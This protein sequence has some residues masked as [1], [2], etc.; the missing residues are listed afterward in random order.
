VVACSQKSDVPLTSAHEFLEPALKQLGSRGKIGVAHWCPQGGSGIDLPAT[1]DRQ[2]LSAGRA[3]RGEVLEQIVNRAYSRYTIAFVPPRF[4]KNWHAVKIRLSAE[5]IRKHAPAR[6][7]YRSGYLGSGNAP[8]YSV[9]DV[10][11]GSDYSLNASLFQAPQGSTRTQ[12]I[13]FNV[14]G[15][16][17]EG[18]SRARFTL[19]LRDDRV[20]SWT[21]L[22]DGGNR[23]EITMVIAFLTRQGEKIEQRVHAH[24]IVRRQNDSWT[25]L[26]QRIVIDNYLEYPVEADGIRFVIRDDATGRIGSQDVPMQKILDAPKLPSTIS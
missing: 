5:A 23:S 16:T 17:Y 4:D 24:Q 12:G 1:E 8:L 21:A 19:K 10:S 26:N 2:A 13:P 6:L 3:S 22:P 25:L 15:A 18:S 11:R 9:T 14:E 7:V 20:L